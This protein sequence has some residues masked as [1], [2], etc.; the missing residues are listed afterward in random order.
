MTNIV[1]VLQVLG[2]P[3]SSGTAEVIEAIRGI[4]RVA[5]RQKE[6][7]DAMEENWKTEHARVKRA[8]DPDNWRVVWSGDEATADVDSTVLTHGNYLTL[9]GTGQALFYFRPCCQS[10]RC[11]CLQRNAE[12][13]CPC[14]D[15][16]E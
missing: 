15:N 16:D 7:A 3:L 6:R 12:G 14:H 2:L 5:Q 1:P 4:Q 8:E 10:L 13:Y 9:D 11:E